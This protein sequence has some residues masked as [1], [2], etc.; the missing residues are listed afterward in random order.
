MLLFLT[1]IHYYPK[2]SKQINGYK[3]SVKTVEKVLDSYKYHIE[4]ENIYV[5]CL[6]KRYCKDLYYADE[7]PCIQ[8][9]KHVLCTIKLI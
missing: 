2:K 1:S 3:E 6:G 7:V 9:F 4:T 8:N 5:I